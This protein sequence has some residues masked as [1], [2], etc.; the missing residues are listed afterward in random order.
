MFIQNL[1]GLKLIDNNTFGFFDDNIV[2][3][4]EKMKE[5]GAISYLDGANM[6]SWLGFLAPGKMGFDIAHI[7]LHKTLAVP[8]GGGGPG[9]GPILCK[10][11][12]DNTQYNDYYNDK[13][14]EQMNNVIITYLTE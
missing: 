5:I 13:D 4:L 2:Q 6:N 12:L 10:R 7:N 14:D 8:H 11:F 9:S 1:S 3:T